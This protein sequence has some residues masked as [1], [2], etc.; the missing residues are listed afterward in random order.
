MAQSKGEF[1]EIFPSGAIP[2]A[3]TSTL[4]VYCRESDAI[5][6][7]LDVLGGGHSEIRVRPEFSFSPIKTDANGVEIRPTVANQTWGRGTVGV[8]DTTAGVCNINDDIS[9]FSNTLIP[10]GEIR[11][12]IVSYDNPGALA[13]RFIFNGSGLVGDDPGAI[14][15]TISEINTTFT[16][17]R[18]S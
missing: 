12:L 3:E 11:R 2:S 17:K 15:A 6:L 9:A 1:L 4:A 5:N 7:I 10:S 8:W 13:A 18:I 16:G 14:V